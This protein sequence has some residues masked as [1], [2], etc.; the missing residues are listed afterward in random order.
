MKSCILTV[1][2][3]E[4]EY[5]DEWIKY[6]LDLGIDHIFIFEDIGS[7]SHKEITDRYVENVTLNNISTIL[8]DWDKEKALELKLTK[9]RSV[10][11]LYLNKCLSYM[12]NEYSNLYDWCFTIDNDE[13]IILENNNLDDTL[14][15]YKD[16]EAFILSW[17]CYGA[18]GL[19]SKPN[20]S[21]NSTINIYD[22]SIDNRYLGKKPQDLVKTCYN[23]KKYKEF[24]FGNTHNPSKKCNW[25]NSIYVKDDTRPVYKNIHLNHYITKS[26]EEY[27]WKVKKRGYMWG[28][29]KN[30]DFFFKVNPDMLVIKDKLMNIIN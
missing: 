15:L 6:H 16:Y 4:H 27:V 3:N 14:T 13:F 9:K 1:I 28:L 22:K 12:K 5:L 10:H 7:D 18:N 20:Y 24:F 17:K 25:C 23:L 26:W 8:N 30:Y 11:P 19:I 29:D 2:K 21:E